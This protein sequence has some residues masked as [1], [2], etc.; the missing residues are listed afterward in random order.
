MEPFKIARFGDDITRTSHFFQPLRNNWA[1]TNTTADEQEALVWLHGSVSPIAPSCWDWQNDP[2]DSAAAHGC[3]SGSTSAWPLASDVAPP[4]RNLDHW[5]ATDKPMVAVIMWGTN[6]LAASPPVGVTAYTNNMREIV[7]TCKDFGTIP[8]LTTIPPRRDFQTQTVGDS[9]YPLSFPAVR[10]TYVQALIDLAAE[11]NVPLIDLN[12]EILARRSTSWDGTLIDS[13]GVHLSSGRTTSFHP[14]VLNTFGYTL[15]NWMTL[16]A[17]WDVQNYVLHIGYY[18]P[19]KIKVYDTAAT[20]VPGPQPIRVFPIPA[21]AVG[22]APYGW[23]GAELVYDNWTEGLV[24]STVAGP[25][26]DSLVSLP[27]TRSKVTIHALYQPL[28][29]EPYTDTNANGAYDAG[30]PFTDLDGNGTW[31]VPSFVTPDNAFVVQDTQQFYVTQ[32]G[33]SSDSRADNRYPYAIPRLG[34]SHA[35]NG[36]SVLFDFSARPVRRFGVFLPAASDNRS[37]DPSTWKDDQNFQ[38]QDR[39]VYVSVIDETGTPTQVYRSLKVGGAATY[40]PFLSIAYDGVHKIKKVSIIHDSRETTGKGVSFMD[41]YIVPGFL[42]PW[43]SPDPNHDGWVN[44]ADLQLL[45]AAWGSQSRSTC[46]QLEPQCRHQRRW[47]CQRR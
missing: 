26:F 1:F 32:Q 34:R 8:I 45:V 42:S 23:Q 7:R 41:A 35:E 25:P 44:V 27:I 36:L 31:T 29:G 40:C 17:I 30:E 14:A 11:M 33:S 46:Q 5:L 28:G 16:H 43:P 13:D 10:G 6:D 21:Q 24:F 18:Q 2:E 37:P 47:L 39:N 20:D 15:R 3:K 9:N 38:K 22:E 19:V 4:A 12:K